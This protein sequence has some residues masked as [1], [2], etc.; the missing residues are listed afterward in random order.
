MTTKRAKTSSS[1]HSR[2]CI[3]FPESLIKYRQVHN[4]QE[5]T[6]Q[7]LRFFVGVAALLLLTSSVV[8]QRALGAAP[9]FLTQAQEPALAAQAA[10][11]T[12]SQTP[13]A[14]A[15]NANSAESSSKGKTSGSHAHD[16][17]IRGTVFQPNALAFPAVQ[18]RIRRAN[19]KKFRWETYTNSRGEFAVRVPQGLQYEV[20]IHRK[21]FADQTREVDARSG[22][23]EDNVV[24]R[25][26][27]SGTPN[28]GGKK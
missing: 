26:E 4:Q 14:P 1:Q 6:L 24:F 12:Q 19:K 9:Q 16:F 5:R 8:A 18:L 2:F 11:A 10:P 7:G 25:M 3:R 20:V 27:P 15:T 28:N 17:L 23:S 13:Q 22:I 21:G